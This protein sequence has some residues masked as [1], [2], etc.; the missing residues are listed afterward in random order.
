MEKYKLLMVA[1]SLLT[2]LALGLG[3]T[4]FGQGEFYPPGG[5]VI[6]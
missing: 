3:I 5:S 2:I 4:A 6:P 1:F